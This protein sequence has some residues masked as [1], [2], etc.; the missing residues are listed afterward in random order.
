MPT[1][2]K[3]YT[4]AIPPAYKPPVGPGGT[5]YGGPTLPGMRPP[6]QPGRTGGGVGQP[7][8]GGVGVTPPPLPPAPPQPTP[9]PISVDE[10]RPIPG[11][12]R[13]MPAW[14]PF[15]GT[16]FPGRGVPAGGGLFR[17]PGYWG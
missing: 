17:G 12:P 13:P 15:G 9:G 1:Y 7:T 5:L 10:N 3:R 16:T 11:R 8:P 2:N 14:P 4:P 6:A